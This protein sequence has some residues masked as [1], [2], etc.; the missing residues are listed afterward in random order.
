MSGL[1]TAT[2]IAATVGILGAA[3]NSGGQA[4]LSILAVPGLLSFSTSSTTSPISTQALAQQWAGIYNRGK[5]LGPQAAALSLL[6]YG[7]LAYAQHRSR[8]SGWQLFVG[9]AALTVG[10]VPFTLVFMDATNQVLLEVASGAATVGSEA[11]E[12]LLLRWKDLNL[13]RSFFPLAGAVVGL[14][15]LLG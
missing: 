8:G 2:T 13:V 4:M 14:W 9:A 7:Y 3:W 12:G 15:G 5:V 10:I 6:G 11:L 1:P